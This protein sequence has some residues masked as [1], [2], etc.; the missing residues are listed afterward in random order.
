[1]L[2]YLQALTLLDQR[3]RED[4]AAAVHAHFARRRDD[5]AVLDRALGA[6]LLG[7]D[8]AEPRRSPPVAEPGDGDGSVSSASGETRQLNIL[9]DADDPEVPL[10]LATYSATEVLRHKDFAALSDEEMRAVRRMIQQ[11]VTPAGRRRSRRYQRGGDERLDLRRVLR[12]SL[13][14]NGEPLLFAWRRR[15]W[16][17]RPVVLLCDISGSMERYTRLLLH[18]AYAM[19]NASERVEA[20]VFATRLTRITRQLRIHNADLAL[21]RVMATVEDWS[22]G[23]R[24][25]ESI[26]DF[27]RRF[28]RRFLGHGATAV[29]ISDGWDRGDPALLAQATLRL[30]RS[31]H[32]LIWMNP[33]MGAPG[34][35]PLTL[36]L[37]AVLPYVDDFI[38]AHNLVSLEQL[39]ELLENLDDRR[40]VRRQYLQPA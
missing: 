24:I 39:Q 34:F 21:D 22:G 12:Q 10:A 19:E 18:F 14:F 25:G 15:R 7:A 35:E 9:D 17:P 32:R 23:T 31:C 37:R 16:K 5:F 40:Q 6:F 30:Q 4:V 36:G 29:V 33:L 28:G 1:M 11:M 20:F 13:R 26:D 27:N 38:S 2:P 8:P 3:R